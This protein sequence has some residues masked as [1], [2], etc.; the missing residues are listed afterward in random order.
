M[1]TTTAPTNGQLSVPASA[2]ITVNFSE[3]VTATTSSF[4]IECPTGSPVAYTLSTSPSSSFVLT[5]SGALPVGSTCTVTVVANQIH[6]LDTPPNQV[7]SNVVF[8]FGVAP[9]AV[10]DSFSTAGNI[11][12]TVGASGGVLSNDQPP[13]GL[14][15]AEVQ[16]SSANVGTRVDTTRVGL[17]GVHGSVTLRTDGSLDYDPP[18]GFTSG[19]DTF[20]YR[21]S[22]TGGTSNVATVA[23]N[24]SSN[25]L[26]FVCQACADTDRGTGL[27][28]LL[29][30]FTSIGAFS[31]ANTGASP[32]PQA[33]QKIF[34]ESGTYSTVSDTTLVLLSSQ[35]VDGQ[36]RAASSV[37]TPPANANA[38]FATLGAST[39]PVLQ[40]PSGDAIDLSTNNTVQFLNV[41]STVAGAAHISGSTFGS[42][43]LNNVSL[44]TATSATGR[45]LALSNGTLASASLASVTSTGSSGGPAIGLTNLAGSLSINGGVISG[46]S[47]GATFAVSGGT[48]SV[49]DSGTL[50]QANNQPL[51]SVSSGHTTGTLT[52]SGSLT[53]TNGSGLQF[54]NADG[55]YAL[56][57]TVTLNGGTAGIDVFDLSSGSIS[58]SATSSAITN[59]TNE[60]VKVSGAQG[61]NVTYAGTITKTNGSTGITITNNTGGTLTFSGG[62]KTVSTTTTSDAVDVT[63]NTT[64][65]VNF[66]GGGLQLTTV[67]GAGLNVSGGGTVSVGTGT[68]TNT[69]TTQ[70]GTAL[71]VANTTIGATGLTFHDISAGTSTTG[72]ANA[73]VLNSTGTTG[74]FTVTGSGTAGSG[75]TI[76]HTTSDAISLNNAITANLQ[77]MNVNNSA[78]R[79][80]R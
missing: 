30:P 46:A 39:P 10:D 48:L 26:W 75:G 50:S 34:I 63:G 80:I 69:I 44:G 19:A 36:G 12:I 78:G 38:R 79:A 52:F 27:G 42:L 15:V 41:G 1:V 2:T 61:A 45:P 56:S 7:P 16:G 65:T 37:L 77:W 5:P 3:S 54:D 29:D 76:Q 17:N 18:P 4:T 55:T 22:N 66:S 9:Q 31:A 73:I 67:G 51:L 23:V 74:G 40:P 49:T 20:T 6:D 60:A 11:A 43:T 13:S 35:E 71:S 24:V 21:V 58:I 8:S 57:G 32:A 25:I 14:V 62:T 47:G 28:T 68:P 53:A 70:T 72:P 64:T 33:N 59:P